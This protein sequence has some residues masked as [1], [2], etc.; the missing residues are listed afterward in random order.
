MKK[1]P[2]PHDAFFKSLMT[3]KKVAREFFSQHLPETVVKAIDLSTLVLC[4]ETYIDVSL[5]NSASDL[6]Y[7]VNLKGEKAYIYILAEH[8]SSC[9]KLMPFRI[10]K[11]TCAIMDKHQKQYPQSKLPS[12]SAKEATKE[13]GR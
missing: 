9:D 1:I 13:R 5:K 3:N 11:Y 8:Q 6:L 10:L 4:S 12:L 2:N 7:S